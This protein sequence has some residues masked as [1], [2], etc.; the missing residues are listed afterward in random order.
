V[1]LRSG[2]GDG[3]MDGWIWWRERGCVWQF[4]GYLD[5]IDVPVQCPDVHRCEI[6]RV[7]PAVVRVGSRVDEHF[8]ELGDAPIGRPLQWGLVP[9]A[10]GL[11]HVLKTQHRGAE[12]LL[13]T[14]HIP[15]LRNSCG[16]EE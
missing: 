14:G 2:D 8:D 11:I 6:V 9:Q 5:H 3:W 10:V 16:S 4:E 12:D 15:T 13:H 7:S 1:Q